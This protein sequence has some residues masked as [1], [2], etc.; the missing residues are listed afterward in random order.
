MLS[1]KSLSSALAE[2]LTGIT[3][4]KEMTPKIT[5]GLE[6]VIGE[7]TK[8]ICLLLAAYI[9]DLLIPTLFLMLAI[10]PLRIITGGEHC[11]SSLRCLITTI[12]TYLLMAAASAF[13]AKTF[14]LVYLLGFCLLSYCLF[15]VIVDRYGPGY[16]VNYPNP[17]QEVIEK[18]KR[19]V[20]GAMTIYTIIILNTFYLAR[21]DISLLFL[22]S[23]AIGGLWQSLMITAYGERLIA[24]I[25]KGLLFAKIK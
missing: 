25:D 15:A 7:T 24:I 20:F 1:V 21:E 17:S 13:L 2:K 5:Y 16:S 4:Q 14:P 9:L 11:T 3:G 10:I 18:I 6:M 22:A 8:I 19:R 12:V 23:A